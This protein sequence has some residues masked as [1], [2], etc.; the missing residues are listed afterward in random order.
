LRKRIDDVIAKKVKIVM[1]DAEEQEEEEIPKEAV[2][3]VKKPIPKRPILKKPTQQSE[4]TVK[5]SSTEESMGNI[6]ERRKRQEKIMQSIAEKVQEVQREQRGQQ[7]E[8]TTVEEDPVKKRAQE[9]DKTLQQRR[10]KQ[11][12]EAYEKAKRLREQKEEESK[13][14]MKEAYE[15]IT[16]QR[17]K[18]I[19]GVQ[20]AKQEKQAK[21][22]LQKR[23]KQAKE[24]KQN[25]EQRKKIV[26]LN[27]VTFQKVELG[28]KL[29]SVS[30]KKPVGKPKN[31]MDNTMITLDLFDKVIDDPVFLD[32]YRKSLIKLYEH[33]L[34][35]YSNTEL[36]PSEIIDDGQP[37]PP[38][39]PPVKT[40]FYD[41]M[42][43]KIA[44]A[45]MKMKYS[46]FNQ[47]I[48]KSLKEAIHD[49]KY[50][51]LSL[52]GREDIMNR[53]CRILYSFSKNANVL[54]K[55]FMNFAIYGLPG[56]GKT[57]LAKVLAYVFKKSF[58]LVEGNIVFATQ[59][60]LVGQYVGHSQ[61][62]TRKQLFNAVEGVLFVDEAYSLT[63]CPEDTTK[64]MFSGEAIAELINFMDKMLGLQI[65]MVAGYED[66]MV[67][68]FFPSNEGL[69]RRFPYKWNL[70]NYTTQQLTVILI[71]HLVDNDVKV[72]AK[73]SNVLYSMVDDLS[74]KYP[75]VFKN[76]AGDM[77]N[78]GNTL[79]QTSMASLNIEWGETYEGDLALTYS[80]LEQFLISK[81]IYFADDTVADNVAAASA[82]V[83][84]N[85]EIV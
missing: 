46:T 51:M 5:K 9:A 48:Q 83:N 44:M 29:S 78:L 23:E 11:S 20:K 38:F 54:F 32:K 15:M 33:K 63:P 84:P 37:K 60:E 72:S 76:Q 77:L 42:K 1:E 49:E 18:E 59:Q 66:K 36:L 34:V 19:I 31:M 74:V 39:P 13:R 75:T 28:L 73:I 71:N 55:I 69:D 81:G 65:I 7:V 6:V 52:I 50:G 12:K 57:A 21:E 24:L 47:T 16:T 17:H 40:S 3:L 79:I 53:I 70:K 61:P 80:G 25:Q 4:E 10:D 62:K 58:I 43:D 26:S 30:P 41:K 2:P 67:R 64:N 14:L 8:S 82:K 35:V 22:K 85:D 68:C 56:S 27:N 45:L